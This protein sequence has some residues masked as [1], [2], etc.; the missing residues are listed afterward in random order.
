MSKLTRLAIGFLF[1]TALASTG[2]GESKCEECT[3]CSSFLGEYYGTVESLN[4]TCADVM[5]LTGDEY[6]KVL[7]ATPFSFESRD[8]RGYWS[9]FEGTLCNT[10]DEDYPKQYSF[11]A[12]YRPDTTGQDYSLDYTLVG[13]FSVEDETSEVITVTA[14]LDLRFVF[15]DGE[16]C[17]LS[18]DVR[19]S[20][21]L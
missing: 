8:S 10:A 17:T 11:N 5:L 9:V 16:I 3:D 12:Y 1:V 2:C 4:E 15:D 18:G 14:S 20:K 19:L 21:A 6:M 7:S 13:F